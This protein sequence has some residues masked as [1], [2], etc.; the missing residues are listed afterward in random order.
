[1][2][3]KVKTFCKWP[4]S[5]EGDITFLC[6]TE[7]NGKMFCKKHSRKQKEWIS[8]RALAEAVGKYRDDPDAWDH[9]LTA[10]Y[11]AWKAMRD[12]E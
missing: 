1:M 8:L 10:A 2:G 5:G 12:V 9:E 4:L 3:E 11:D 7:T 6:C